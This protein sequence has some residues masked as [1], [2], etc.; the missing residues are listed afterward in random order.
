M[1]LWDDYESDAAFE[2]AY[3]HGVPCG[4]WTTRDG[5]EIKLS[6]MTEQH[7]MNCMRLVGEDDPWFSEFYEELKRRNIGW[8]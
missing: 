4:V 6:D 1:S 3:P 8:R 2:L 7:I 5:T